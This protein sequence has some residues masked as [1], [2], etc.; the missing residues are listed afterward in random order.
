MKTIDGKTGRIIDDD[1]FT[2]HE[3]PY[4]HR[5][6]QGLNATDI[7]STLNVPV[8]WVVWAGIVLVVLPFVLKK[9]R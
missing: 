1:V 9:G 7:A 8:S 6:M 4:R 3:A 2:H 5:P